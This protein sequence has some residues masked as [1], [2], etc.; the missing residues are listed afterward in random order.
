MN[1]QHLICK[2]GYCVN[3]T[4]TNPIAQYCYTLYLAATSGI[5][6]I[7]LFNPIIMYKRARILVVDSDLH[8][9]SKIYLSLIHKDYKVEATD[10]AQEIIA[11]TERFRPRLLILNASAKNLNSEIYRDLAKK[12]LHVILIGNKKE[13]IPYLKKLEVVQMPADLRFFDT[14]IR[15]TLNIFE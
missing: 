3:F 8:S 13:E 1:V 7:L 5:L 6:S 2:T 11:R 15:E 10:D 14:K 9:L 4:S 12:R